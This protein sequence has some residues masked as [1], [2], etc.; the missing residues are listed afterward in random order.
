MKQACQRRW[1]GQGPKRRSP[2]TPS[3]PSPLP[4][5]HLQESADEEEI[6]AVDAIYSVTSKKSP[7]P[8]VVHVLVDEKPVSF[9]VD[10]GAGKS[11]MSDSVFKTLW[12]GRSLSS[13]HYYHEVVLLFKG[14]HTSLSLCCCQGCVQGSECTAPSG[15]HTPW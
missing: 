3:N 5:H 8:V 4:V 6:D 14:S 12:P 11:L 7:P 1:K 9:E 13:V 2:K 10:T 15:S